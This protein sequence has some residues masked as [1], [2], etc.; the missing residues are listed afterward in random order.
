MSQEEKV[1]KEEQA[2]LELGMSNDDMAIDSMQPATD[3]AT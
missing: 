1:Q 3:A 2:K